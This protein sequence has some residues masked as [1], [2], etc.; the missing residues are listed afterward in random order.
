M[1]WPRKRIA[2]VVGYDAAFAASQIEVFERDIAKSRR[3]TLT[4]WE[5]RPWYEKLVEWTAGLVSPQL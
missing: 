2:W 1:A 4:D 3:V 5:A